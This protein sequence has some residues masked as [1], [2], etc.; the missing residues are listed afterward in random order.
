MILMMIYD[1][2]LRFEVLNWLI[3]RRHALTFLL[4][5][6]DGNSA[7]DFSEKEIKMIAKVIGN[8]DASNK[9]WATTHLCL[10]LAEWGATVSAYFHSCPTSEHGFTPGKP[11]LPYSFGHVLG[12]FIYLMSNTFWFKED[13]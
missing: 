12:E 9:F 8:D 5:D 10:Q 3:P 6:L 7:S 11:I 1:M 13:A 4:G 2:Y